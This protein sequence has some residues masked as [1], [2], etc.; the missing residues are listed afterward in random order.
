MKDRGDPC[1]DEFRVDKLIYDGN[2]DQICQKDEG[3]SCTYS[4][5]HRRELLLLIVS[6]S[7]RIG[8]IVKFLNTTLCSLPIPI[9]LLPTRL[10]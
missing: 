1:V 3:D 7:D 6:H 4:P 10:S 5:G 8:I 2:S 9:L